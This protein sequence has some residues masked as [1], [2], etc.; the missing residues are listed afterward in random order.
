M[1][2]A[3]PVDAVDLKI[4]L[5][6]LADRN[7]VADLSGKAW[8]CFAAWLPREVRVV[9]WRSEVA[10]GG[11]DPEVITMDFGEG[12]HFV[13]VGSRALQRKPSAPQGP[14]SNAG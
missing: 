9:V 11:P 2:C 3:I 13:V 1:H 12:D 6:D 4:E 8:P 14:D 5:L 7:P 10:G